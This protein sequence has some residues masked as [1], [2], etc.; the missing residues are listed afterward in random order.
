VRAVSALPAVFR[1]RGD[2]L[3]RRRFDCKRISMR[4]DIFSKQ[5]M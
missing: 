1:W 3:K 5:K 4:T 2:P